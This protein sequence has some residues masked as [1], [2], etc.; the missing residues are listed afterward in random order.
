MSVL[1]LSGL[2][3]SE[4][5][6]EEGVLGHH[7]KYHVVEKTRVTVTPPKT[8]SAPSEGMLK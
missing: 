7:R 8:P 5:E 2:D 3:G 6:E 4:E 1:H